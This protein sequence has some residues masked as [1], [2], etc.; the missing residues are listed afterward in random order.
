MPIN[1]D[2]I[3]ILQELL[4]LISNP[5]S[6][7]DIHHYDDALRDWN[8][9]LRLFKEAGGQRPSGDAERLAFTEILPPDV[10]ARVTLHMD[11]PQYGN[12][13]E[14]RKFTDK[15]VKVMTALARQ[16][17]GVRSEAPVC[18]IDNINSNGEEDGCAIGGAEHDDEDNLVYPALDGLDVDQRIEV[19]AFYAC[20]RLH[21]GR[22]RS[23]R[24]L[25]VTPRRTRPASVD[26]WP[27]QGHATARP[28]RHDQ[29]P[30]CIR[31]PT[32]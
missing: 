1:E 25:S 10:A 21:A 14:L 28:C 27:C 8:T 17:K 23:R 30:R 22:P 13:E 15:Y 9:N 12:F 19:L 4:A 11:L 20:K 26:Q 5:K 2:K 16:R 29:R 7:P 3:L 31:M 6:A 32:A 18:L 24:S